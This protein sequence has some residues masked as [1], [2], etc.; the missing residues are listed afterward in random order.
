MI[1]PKK[2]E[3]TP[4]ANTA[5]S[6]SG[7]LASMMP[8]AAEDH[9]PDL[10]ELDD[11]DQPRLVVIVGELA[12]QRR[13]QEEGQDEQALRDRAELEL[14][15]R[16][17]IELVGDEQHHR[18]LEQAVVE[19]AEELGREQ[20][21]EPPRAQQVGNVL[22]QAGLRGLSWEQGDRIASFARCRQTL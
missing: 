22:D 7:M 10:G 16:V 15:R 11:A 8:G 17:R 3:W 1:G 12:R 14:L 9:D 20:R 18:L 4:I 2:V 5:A 6:I 19:R 21:Q 13:E